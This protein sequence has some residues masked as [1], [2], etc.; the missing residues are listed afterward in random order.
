MVEQRTIYDQ[1]GRPLE[2]TVTWYASA[3]YSFHA[4]LLGDTDGPL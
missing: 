3:R 4:V 1:D 2:R